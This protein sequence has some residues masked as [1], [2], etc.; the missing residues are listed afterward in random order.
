MRPTS[1]SLCHPL[2]GRIRRLLHLS[3]QVICNVA[4]NTFCAAANS[5][6]VGFQVCFCSIRLRIAAGSQSR[7]DVCSRRKGRHV[8]PFTV[9][10]VVLAAA[11]FLKFYCDENAT[12]PAQICDDMGANQRPGLCARPRDTGCPVYIRPNVY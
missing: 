9:C 4:V 3:A 11:D 10:P 5:F 2:G 1:S 6:A 12:C 7:H 8:C